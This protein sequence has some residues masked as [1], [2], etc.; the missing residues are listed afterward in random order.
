MN[1]LKKNIELS[2]LLFTVTVIVIWQ[3]IFIMSLPDGDTDAYAHFII[4][5]DIVRDPYN[6]SLHWVWLPLFHY[7]GAFFVLIG[8]EMQSVRYLNVV[9]WNV[10]PILLYFHLK[11][12]E[13]ESLIPITASIITALFPIGVLMGTTA[14][15]EPLFTLLLLLFVLNFEK[16][17][18]FTSAVFLTLSCMLRYEAWSVL[19]GIGIYILYQIYNNK[20]FRIVPEGKP[21][22]IFLNILLPAIFIFFWSVLRYESDGTWFSFLHGTQ[23]FANDALGQTNSAQGG[24]L[25]LVSDM[26]HYP[27][28]LPFLFVGITIL[29]IPFGF[30]KFLNKNTILFVTGVSVLVFITSSWVL[31]A[32]LGLN[33][34]FTSIIPFYAVMIAYG[35]I[36]IKDYMKK[37]SILFSER[38]LPLIFSTIIIFYASMW[39]Y[40]WQDKNK[41]SYSDKKESIEYIKNLYKSDPNIQIL[42]NDPVI[43]VLSSINYKAFNHFWMGENQETTEYIRNI[44]TKNQPLYLITSSKSEIFFSQIGTKIFESNIS[45]KNGLKIQIFKL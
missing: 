12:K 30:K 21:F 13:F 18:Y 36:S 32:N 11:Q 29:F 3:I 1:F 34:H 16:R 33:R 19:I 22:I 17:N 2:I 7:I 9:I 10:I 28:W 14:Q 20:S 15:P 6:L 45:D 4:A 26:F 35:F 37:Y 25:N 8:S 43:E 23:K 44:K 42:N 41:D 39:M 27:V 5:R 31:K 38:L 24:M 40:I